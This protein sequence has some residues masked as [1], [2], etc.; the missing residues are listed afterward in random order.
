MPLSPMTPPPLR[1]AVIAARLLVNNP[2]AAQ[3]AHP[4]IRQHAW[5]TLAA[6]L[7]QRR[8]SRSLILLPSRGGDAA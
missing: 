8:L 4:Y 6:D 2:E 3:R 1:A 7:R 5:W